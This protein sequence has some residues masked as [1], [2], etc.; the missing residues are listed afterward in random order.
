MEDKNS[1]RLAFETYRKEYIGRL[2]KEEIEP[3]FQKYGKE[4]EEF[5]KEWLL[6][7]KAI[8]TDED[9]QSWLREIEDRLQGKKTEI[10]YFEEEEGHT[11]E[12]YDTVAIELFTLMEENP[13]ILPQGDSV[14]SV[15]DYRF[16]QLMRKLAIDPDWY[17]L[18]L[19]YLFT[20]EIN[21]D[22]IGHPNIEVSERFLFGPESDEL[23]HKIS[24]NVGP[25]T[26]LDD[27]KK[28]WRFVVKPLQ[29][30]I[31]ALWKGKGRKK[32]AMEKALE[33]IKLQKQG[34][35]IKQIL[36]IID[37]KCEVWDE[38]KARKAI[39]RAKKRLQK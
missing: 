25:N 22:L 35:T 27:V 18:F 24:L 36:D 2:F 16:R 12:G 31:K 17:G 3:L 7:D 23:D 13:R 1:K 21:L 32:P 15:F 29:K 30:E 39:A 8:K 38:I 6:G 4:I 9:Y 14:Q 28:V 5:R 20:G 37:P 10:A 26:R 33:M 34:K 19:N 11:L